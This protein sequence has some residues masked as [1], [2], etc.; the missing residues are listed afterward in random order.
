MASKRLTSPNPKKTAA[1]KPKRVTKAQVEKVYN[2]AV[3][4]GVIAGGTTLES[5]IDTLKKS[6]ETIAGMVVAW[7]RYVLI[8]A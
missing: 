8:L 3:D 1:L 6:D 4:A 5:L 7:D 2:A